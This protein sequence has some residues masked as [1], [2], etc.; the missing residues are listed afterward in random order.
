M[1]QTRIRG[2]IVGAL[3]AL[4]AYGVYVA[5]PV[6]PEF[7]EL[8]GPLPITPQPMPPA[9]TD[10]A[11][12]SAGNNNAIAIVLKERDSSWLG[13]VH[14][15]K[16]IG[17]P[18]QIVST[19]AE[20]VQH[21]VVLVYPTLTG[22]NTA[23]EDLQKLAAHVHSG[24]TLIGF[25]VIGGGMPEVFGF[26]SSEE[27]LLRK[28]VQLQSSPL[29]AGLIDEEVAATIKLGAAEDKQDGMPVTTYQLPKWP[30]LA[31]FDDGSAAITGN[32]YQSGKVT[33]H[34]YAFGL[35]L[36]HFIL[37]AENGRF[38]GVA[39]TYVNEYQP[40]VDTFLRLLVAIYRQ[41][42]PDA[43]VLSPTPHNREFSGL[44]THDIDFTRSMTNIPA[45]ME[46]E[47]A[48]HVKATYFVQTKYVKDY[49]DDVFLTRANVSILKAMQ[50]Q[51][52]EIA[53]HTVAHAKMFS[54]M[55]PGSGEE[56][57][58][59][60]QPFVKNYDTV[61]DGSIMG[62]LRVS[63]FLLESLTP[64]QIVSFRP[65]HLSLPKSLPQ[66]LVANGYH[67]SSSITAN[68]ALTHLPYRL[69]DDRAYGSEVNAWEFP[70]TIED[71]AG[72][73][74]DR[75]AAAVAVTEHIARYRGLVNILIHTDMLDHK[76]E[77]ERR[78]LE[79]F[80]KRA[81]FDT[82]QGYGQWWEARD[83][84]QTA[85][86]AVAAGSRRVTLTLKGTIDGLT[87]QI[88]AG[89]HYQSGLDGTTQQDASVILGIFTDKAELMFTLDAP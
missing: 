86:N 3:V 52:M 68:Q 88:P 83:S 13:L 62:E 34:A 36:G 7:P 15:F 78:Y 14:G 22:G 35:D 58:P 25:S 48:N 85:V 65:G 5:L 21:K 57:Y 50:A 54:T 37:R 29:T 23:A 42:E 43:I 11:Q 10:P 64:T 67:Y 44:I 56:Q 18:F 40:Q 76:L 69:M 70:V 73:L 60:Y 45:Y 74:G 61:K 81:W 46:M 19:V 77:F 80:S 4:A 16:S 24:G 39:A 2:I 28:N 38:T 71:E 59:A 53:S 8:A 41:G 79:L 17:I 63:K 51:Q 66:M 33:G 27:V 32:S 84:V 87:L 55:P 6:R 20:A 9:A 31:L 26:G 12:Y 30:A 89:W 1:G 47:T 72:R 75:F 49:S 82:V